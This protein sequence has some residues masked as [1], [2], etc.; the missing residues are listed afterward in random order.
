MLEDRTVPLGEVVGRLR[1]WRLLGSCAAGGAVAG[2][3]CMLS[4]LVMYSFEAGDGG[5]IEI[6][7]PFS[8][9]LALLAGVAIFV[10]CAGSVLGAVGSI[11]VFVSGLLV[12]R[13]GGVAQRV[14]PPL[15]GASVATGLAAPLVF[16]FIRVVPAA[17]L[18]ALFI[19]SGS[20]YFAAV[21]L[22]SLRARR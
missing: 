6:A 12:S 5:V 22:R 20:G 17:F 7:A 11:I 8:G 9:G 3:V 2:L 13:I 1:F 21:S 19:A 15:L 18:A 4:A 14:I 16:Q 10:A